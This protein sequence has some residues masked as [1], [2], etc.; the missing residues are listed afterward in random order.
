MSEFSNK[1]VVVTGA[2]GGI[3]RQHALAFAQ[4][5]ARVVVNDLGTSVDGRGAGKSADQVVDEIRAAGGTAVASYASVADKDEARSI[6]DQAVSEYGTLDILVNNAGILRNRTFKNMPIEDLDLVIQVHLLGSSY[7]THAAWPVMYENNYGRIVLTTSVSGIF[8]AFGQSAY[9]AAKMGML[10]LMN[11]LA[12]EGKSH[13]ISVNCLSPAADTRML[14]LNDGVD[15]ENPREAMHP[16]LVSAVALFLSS[17]NAPTGLVLH[18]LGN[19]YF[20]SET[21]RNPGVTLPVDA[22]YEDLIEH[23][24][25]LLDMSEFLDREAALKAIAEQT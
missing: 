18:A 2:G 22:T 17:E 14:A 23:R 4:R 1:V 5:G 20:R 24:E 3:G 19:Q 12:L 6:V 13:N 11:A 9:A 21:I 8:G 15:A 7:V 10:G 25:E 16:H